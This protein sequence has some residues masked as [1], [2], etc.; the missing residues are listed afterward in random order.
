[1][2]ERQSQRMVV[3][4]QR[5]QARIDAAIHI[6]AS[7]RGVVA[8]IRLHRE[9]RRKAREEDRIVHVERQLLELNE[10]LRGLL[11]AQQQQQQEQ[12]PSHRQE[13]RRG[14]GD[15]EK[16]RRRRRHRSPVT[17]TSST[18]RPLAVPLAVPDAAAVGQTMEEEVPTEHYSFLKRSPA[19]EEHAG[20]P[21]EAMDS[22][23]AVGSPMGGG[24]PLNNVSPSKEEEEEEEES[25]EEVDS[26]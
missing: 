25:D 11:V 22:W 14:G 7:I 20:L 21:M 19:S 23:D 9:M 6:Q 10:V 15:G 8:R 3:L 1:V 16:R 17:A 13:S 5:K 12:R 4:Q 26:D 18:Q 2:A 24:S